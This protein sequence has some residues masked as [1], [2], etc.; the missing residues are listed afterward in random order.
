V[1]PDDQMNSVINCLTAKSTW[2][3]LILYKALMNELVNDGIKLSKLEI[4]TGFI[5]RLPKKWLSFCL[6]LRNTNNVK[7]SELASLFSKLKYEENL[8]ENIYETGKNK[9]LVSATT[10]LTAF[11]SSSIIQDFQDSLGDEEDTRSRHEYLND[12]EEEYQARAL[13]AKIKRFFKKGSQ[14]FSSA[15][16]T[17]QTECHKCGKN[18]EVSSDDNEMVEVKVL[19]AL[20]EENDAVSKEDARN[21]KWVKMSM[22]K[23]VNT[24]ILKENKNLRTKLKELK[25]ITETW[26][27]RQKDLVFVKS[28]VDDT[29]VTI[30]GVERPWLSEAEGFI[31]PNHDTGRILPAESQRNT[32]D[33]L[34]A[35]T[36]SSATDYDSADESSGCSTHLPPLKKLDGAEPISG[37]KTIKSILRSKSTFKAEALKG[38][39]INEQSSAPAKGNKSSSALKVHSAPAGKLKSVKIKDDPPLAIVMKELNN[40]KLQVSKN[41]SSY[42]RILFCKRCEKTD[43]RTCD[44]AEYISTMNMPQHLKSLGRASSRSKIPR[45]S[46]C[47]FP[48]CTHCGRIDHLSNECLYYPICGL[49]GSYDHDTNGHNRIIS[50][51]REINPRNPQHTFK[52]CEVCGSS[53][54]TTTD[55]YDI[56]WFKRGEALQAKKA[57]ALKSTRAESS[58]ANRSKTPTKSGCSRHMTGVKSYLHKYV[59][60]PGPKVVFGDDSTC[61]TEG[62]GSIKCNG[63]VFTKVAFVDGLKYNLISISQLCDAKYIVQFDE[64]RGT[65]FNSNKEVVMI[66]P[67]VRD[68]YVLDMTSSAQESCFLAKAS[69]NINRLWHKCHTPKRGLDG[70]RVWGSDVII[71]I[72]QSTKNDL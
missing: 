35:V 63:I 71:Y 56:E 13:L 8:I 55:H 33:P 11:F 36:D 54:H 44:H 57:E 29:K 14:R 34:V 51:E 15:K 27:N 1:L 48:P 2:D 72:T 43:H 67:R 49:C 50:L 38:V 24:E 52:R 60:Q 61:T 7:D 45:P 3:D 59:E 32:T 39:I 26:L 12:L 22:R 10:L 6:S 19:M 9:S 37:P 69:E 53:T 42:S 58:N 64:K 4:N 46:K 41:Q 28:S 31:L 20:A 18:E 70:I 47:F 30:P 5:N 66:A 40:L 68:V 62:Y 25:A 23:H 65:I 21:G 17:N 16:A